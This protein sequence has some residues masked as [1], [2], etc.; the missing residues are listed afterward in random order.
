LSAHRLGFRLENVID[1][2]VA[3]TQFMADKLRSW[4][5]PSDRITIVRYFTASHP[6]ATPPGRTGLYLGR[7]SAEKGV[8]V[9]LEALA[10]AGDPAFE[11]AGGGPADHDLRRRAADLG[12]M[13]VTF[14]GQLEKAGVNDAL[15]RARYVVVPSIWDEPF[16]IVALEALAAGRPVIGTATGG[17]EE[18]VDKG[19]GIVIPP[20]DADALA[21]AIGRCVA[22]DE[23][24]AAAAERGRA[25]A[26]S[27]FTPLVHLAALERMYAAVVDR[28]PRTR[29]SRTPAAIRG[30]TSTVAVGTA[31]QSLDKAAR[32]ERGTA[33]ETRR[34]PPRSP[35]AHLTPDLSVCVPTFERSGLL[36]RALA[37]VVDQDG[38]D[39][40][41]IELLV[42]DNSPAVSRSVVEPYLARWTGPTRYLANE[43][44][45]GPIPNFN[46]CLREARGTW[47]LFVHD[48]DYL[49]PDAMSSILNAI[50]TAD[51]DRVLLFGVDVV[52]ERGRR[53]RRQSFEGVERLGPRRALVRLMSD[54]SFVRIP[55]LVI[56]RDVFDE[57]GGFDETIG[58]P[59]DLD[60]LTRVFARYGVRCEPRTTAAYSV[61]VGAA[62]SDMFTADTVATLMTIFRRARDLQVLPEPVLDRCET[63]FFHHF[64]L[65]GAYR[66]LRA[67]E[68]RR[69]S[70]ILDLFDL[71]EVDS[72]GA[73]TR[74]RPVRWLFELVVRLPPGVASTAM[75]A[76]GRVSPER[77]MSSW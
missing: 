75:R 39:G 22:D 7:L 43:P 14:L 42:S 64:I 23:L 3:P 5:I 45:I 37:S 69:A 4:G 29:P 35:G 49:L 74:W 18:L 66:Q 47:I 20:S 46:Q 10:R 52:D 62:T 30:A 68:P 17:L 9:L 28:G 58:S 51:D 55:S 6:P 54:S 12:L 59:T 77:F 21:A 27:D 33:S 76:I 2:F 8:D 31:P 65:G 36:A 50:D 44:S 73:S 71:P 61:H 63:D 56:R 25:V 26:N 34:R 40:H 48:D 15:Q 24:I 11:I 72:L 57:I 41:R 67:G 1:C 53:R 19:G 13:N 16:G 38:P 32:A 60:L 70:E